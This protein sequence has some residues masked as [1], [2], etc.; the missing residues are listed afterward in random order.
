MINMGDPTVIPG[1]MGRAPGGLTYG[2]I[3]ELLHGVA[4]RAPIIGFNIVEF[5]PEADIDYLGARTVCRL[6]MLGAGLMA[7]ASA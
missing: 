5:V 2:D 4:D 3:V 7:R 1:V 6:A